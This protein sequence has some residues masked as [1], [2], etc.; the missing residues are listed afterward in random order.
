MKTNRAFGVR[1]CDPDLVVSHGLSGDNL[2]G[3]VT[4]GFV[5]EFKDGPTRR[6]RVDMT[7]EEARALAAG[8]VQM[9]DFLHS[10]QNPG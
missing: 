5:A 9:A 6:F 3:H 10:T 7:I 8:L 4:L 2:S 1:F